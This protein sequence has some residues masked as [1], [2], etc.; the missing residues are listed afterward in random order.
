MGKQ[1]RDAMTRSVMSAHPSQSL[2]DV[3][4]VI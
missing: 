1:V 3:A 4:R 2:A